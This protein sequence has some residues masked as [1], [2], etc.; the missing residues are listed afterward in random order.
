M[1]QGL[2]PCKDLDAEL[3]LRSRYRGPIVDILEAHAPGYGR[4][5]YVDRA[6]APIRSTWPIMLSLC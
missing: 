4:D 1:E 3:V 6:Q 5:R 2:D